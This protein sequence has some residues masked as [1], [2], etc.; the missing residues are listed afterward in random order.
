MKIILTIILFAIITSS[1]AQLKYIIDDFEGCTN[2]GSDL[3]MNGIFSFG[4]LKATINLH[5]TIQ[6]KSPD[7]LGSRFI[8]LKNELN[9]E[10]GGW[11]KGICLSINLDPDKDCL[12][13]FV[14]QPNDNFGNKIKIQIQEDDNDSNIFEIEA[15]DAWVYEQS[16]TKV[17]DDWQLISIPLNKFK[18]EN[19]GGDGIFNCSYKNGKLLCF[20]ISFLNNQKV[21]IRSNW[22]KHQ[23]VNFDFV[24][25]S[26]GALQIIPEKISDTICNLGLWS[27]EGNTSNFIDIASGFD[28][29]FKNESEKKLSVIHFFQPYS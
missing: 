4:S 8:C 24:C 1:G 25:F 18:D 20:I 19:S 2:G 17:I 27:V 12:N 29:L 21:A 10:Y 3:K 15:D 23:F 9:K 7:Y 28:N 6:K 11:G 26:E 13:F 14:Q 22:A 16:I 5:N